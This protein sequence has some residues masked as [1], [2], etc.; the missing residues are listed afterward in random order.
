MRPSSGHF[1]VVVAI[2]CKGHE[3]ITRSGIIISRY[4]REYCLLFTDSQIIRVR[5][6]IKFVFIIEPDSSC[7][8]WNLSRLTALLTAYCVH[9]L[10]GKIKPEEVQVVSVYIRDIRLWGN[11]VAWSSHG[12]RA[13]PTTY[14]VGTQNE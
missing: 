1:P 7:A 4:Q 8:T 14:S 6:H 13:M 10:E 9:C 12:L 11:R 5:M 3:I 2:V